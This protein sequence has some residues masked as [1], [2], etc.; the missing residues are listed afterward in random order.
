MAELEPADLLVPFPRKVAPRPGFFSLVQP[1]AFR[2]PE[3]IAEPA[4]GRLRDELERRHC[5]L[6]GGARSIELVLDRA[7][8]HPPEGYS[9]TIDERRILV[10]AARP[11][12]F[13]HG[14]HTLCQLVRTAERPWI[15]TG[16]LQEPGELGIPALAI[17][18][19]PAFERRGVMLDVSRDRVPRMDFLR[20]L[21]DRLAEWKINELQLYFEH[22]FAYRDHERVWRGVDPFTPDEIR[23]LDDYC[24]ARGIE[25]VPNQQSFGH[26][27]H[28][29]VH[30]PYRSFAEL[31]GGLLHPF[32]AA[33]SR[34]PEP[35]S[36][37]PTDPRSLA[38]LGALYDELLPCFRSRELNVGLDET[39]DLGQGRSAE[40]CRRK[41]RGRVYLDFLKSVHRLVAERG[42]RMHVWADGVLAHPE[43]ARE[44]PKDAVACLWG[45]EAD[46]PFEEETRILADAGLPFYVCPGTSSWQSIGG[47]L[48]NMIANVRSA[49]QRGSERGALGLL[50]ADWGDRGH[51]QPPVAS[52]P[53]YLMAADVA[54]N[55]AADPKRPYR[56]LPRLLSHHVTGDSTSAFDCIS[57][58]AVSNAIGLRVPNASPLSI[59][60]TKF[61]GTF[62]PPEL[63][64]LRLEG[65]RK[66]RDLLERKRKTRQLAEKAGHPRLSVQ[67]GA[68][69]W[70]E[71]G[72]AGELMLFAC[73]L[74]E[75]RLQAGD[76]RPLDFLPDPVRRGLAD[77]LRPLIEEHRSL[78]CERSRPGGLDRSA[79]WLERILE[80][81]VA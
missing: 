36:L 17:E 9:L 40:E 79:R 51:L 76:G 19:A 2:A 5:R 21:V 7:S 57:L 71:L 23:A 14:A 37:C 28:W 50:V 72:W 11:P 69:S 20:L 53:G 30:E 68:L 18:D 6:G 56:L 38:F 64:D 62:P 15:T 47:R 35:F 61:D 67:D 45:Y 16:P 25:L 41:G 33:G 46:H 8:G 39:I 43:L 12:G 59:L 13:A 80:A 44:V 31:P 78:W 4:V 54:W 1:L 22:A 29:L 60:L 63:R 70:R 66:A 65:L 10:V 73:A 77:T 48:E 81:L 24:H 27:H 34:T 32:L 55:P 58:A 26:L 75:A 52:W 74:G 49:A 3:G 42:H